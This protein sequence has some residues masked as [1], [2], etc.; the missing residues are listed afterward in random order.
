[1][2]EIYHAQTLKENI[3]RWIKI[4]PLDAKD[5]AS[6]KVINDV[7]RIPKRQRQCWND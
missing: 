6:S 7:S 5:T 3:V 4:S 1:M 2:S